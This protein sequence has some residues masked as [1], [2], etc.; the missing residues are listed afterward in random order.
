MPRYSIVALL[1]GCYVN[2]APATTTP[3]S[4]TSPYATR[5]ELGAV[6]GIHTFSSDNSLGNPS[7]G[8]S[9]RDSAVFGVR[10][11]A[12]FADHFGAEA[13]LALAPTEARPTI[14]DVWVML[15]EADL[16]YEPIGEPT[17][18]R[19]VPFLRGG[20]ALYDVLSGG[21]ASGDITSGTLVA[22]EVG[23]GA[24]LP[25]DNGWG[26]RADF[27]A[28][29]PSALGGGVT[30]DFEVGLAMYRSFGSAAVAQ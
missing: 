3:A 11:G 23:V 12:Y 14:Y 7:A 28:L 22:P 17:G 15:G 21:S 26:L 19:F 2:S 4:Q 6:A 30:E 20:A 5:V 10:A 24:K 18:A 13:Q 1:S 16:V 25:L 9:L 29:F 27:T 8:G